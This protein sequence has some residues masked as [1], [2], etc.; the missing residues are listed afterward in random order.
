MISYAQ[1]FEDIILNR[2]FSDRDS[3]FY[4]D[5]GAMDPVHDSVTKAFYDRGWRGIN[6]EP[7]Q[8][9]Y[10]R[11]AAERTRD[12]NLNVAVGDVEETR[13]LYVFKNHGLSTFNSQ[14]KE[15]FVAHGYSHEE[16]SCSVTTLAK[17]CREYVGCP[18]DFLKIDAEGWEGP[19]LRGGDWTTFRPTVLVIEA[20]RPMSHEPEWES[21]ESFVL[22]ECSYLFAYFDGVNRFYIA[23]EREELIT[24]FDHPACILDEFRV[25]ATVVAEQREALLRMECEKMRAQLL[26]VEHRSVAAEARAEQLDMQLRKSRSSVG[27]LTERLAAMQRGWDSLY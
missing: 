23:H 6:I 25:Y 21:W 4:V 19:I 13:T 12:I 10:E 24:V 8:Q 3:G 18:I 17:V 20:I 1:N 9:F 14:F 5:I 7:H 11:L 27:R 2:V 15:H 16:V 26:Q 22:A